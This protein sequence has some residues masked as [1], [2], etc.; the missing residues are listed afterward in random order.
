MISLLGFGFLIGMRHAMEADHAAAV[1]TLATKSQTVGSTVR[2]GLTWGLGHTITLLLFGSMVFLLEA[3]VPQRLANW[4]ELAV[5]V[6]LVGLG[7]DVLRK[8][9]MGRIHVHVHQHPQQSPHVH[10]HSHRGQSHHGTLDHQHAHSTAFPYRALFVGLMHG[11]AGSAALI[12]L[13]LQQTVTPLEGIIYIATFGLGSIVGMATLSIVIA[14]PLRYSSR[15]ISWLH[16]GLQ[17]SI[18]AVTIAIGLS[19]IYTTGFSILI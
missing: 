13:T 11:M 2:Q 18:G 4:L 16:N 7:G 3:A 10:I 8:I 5:G 15:S 19:L 6:M 9:I 14:I 1:A 17:G 12:L